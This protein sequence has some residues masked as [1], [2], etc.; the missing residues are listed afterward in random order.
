MRDSYEIKDKLILFF[1]ALRKQDRLLS[2]KSKE[3]RLTL[4]NL[5]DIFEVLNN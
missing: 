3:F 5:V 4:A 1:K 2:I